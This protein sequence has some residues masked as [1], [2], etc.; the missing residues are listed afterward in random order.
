[1][2][3]PTPD[4]RTLFQTFEWHAKSDKPSH[5]ETHSHGSHYARL[6]RLAPSLAG[7]GLNMFW[8]PPGCKA[9]EPSG[10]GNGY[11][12]YDHWDLGEFDQKGRRNTKWGSKEELGDL[13]AALHNNGV[14]GIWDAVLNHKTAGDT[15]MECWAVEVDEN[16]K[17]WRMWSTVE[18]WFVQLLT[19]GCYQTAE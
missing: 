11:D 10:A 1:M 7:L 16:G 19:T 4:N 2:S 18:F 9:N 8:L 3:Q 5:N 17:Q 14:E 6:T 15:T 12:C 13:V